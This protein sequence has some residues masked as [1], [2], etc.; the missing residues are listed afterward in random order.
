M[1]LKRV[2]KDVVAD[3]RAEKMRTFH[4]P[5]LPSFHLHLASHADIFAVMDDK[6]M[7][8][9]ALLL[10]DRHEGH[11]HVT[12][13]EAYLTAPFRDRYEDLV[14]AAQDELEPRAYL[15]RSDDCTF[16]TSLIANGFTME[17]SLAVMVARAALPPPAADGRGLMP[18]DY[19]YLRVAHSLFQHVR[20]PEQ[21]PTVAELEREMDEDRIWVITE[22]NQPV[23]LVVQEEAEAE[24]YCLLDL[25]AP[26]V[27]DDTLVWALLETG[28]RVELEG[29][30]SAAIVDPRDPRKV[31]V[32]RKAGFYTAATYLIFYD[33][34]A[35]RLDVPIISREELWDLVQS[36]EPFHLI[37]VMG[38]DHWQRGHLPK[39]EWVDFRSLSKQARERFQPD[40]AIVVYCNDY[41]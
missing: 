29:K 7:V 13:I 23:G 37:D 25:V 2:S 16:Q 39:S 9:Y 14:A 22:R 36:D 21:A 4:V 8:G 35:G 3:L 17:V 30:I 41:T 18:L 11:D 32:F 38:E 26:H 6:A 40:E 20:T 24:R 10:I 15:A 33:P 27:G 31:E 34:Q 12:L 5:L 28:K 1:E 19:P